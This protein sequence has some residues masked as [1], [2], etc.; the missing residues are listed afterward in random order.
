MLKQQLPQA[1]DRSSSPTRAGVSS[2]RAQD[3]TEDLATR[4]A[5][6]VG[7]RH[8][9]RRSLAPPTERYLVALGSAVQISGPGRSHRHGRDPGD[10]QPQGDVAVLRLPRAPRRV[11]A[12]RGPR[13]AE[14]AR[15]GV[16]VPACSSG[17]G[18]RRPSPTSWRPRS[19]PGAPSTST[20]SSSRPRWP[21]S[22]RS[23]NRVPPDDAMKFGINFLPASL[24]APSLRGRRACRAGSSGRPVAPPDHR[25]VHGA[26]GHRTTSPRLKKQVRALRRLGFGFAVDDAG[27]GYA[28][29]TVIAA[30]EPSIIKIDREI[31]SGVGNKDAEAKKALV[32]AFVSFSRRDRR[33]DRR[34][35]DREPP[36]PA[37]PA[38]SRGRLRPG[39]PARPV[40]HHARSAAPHPR[41]R[42]AAAGHLDRGRL[43]QGGHRPRR[44]EPVD[45]REARS[46][47]RPARPAAVGATIESTQATQ[48]TRP[49][50]AL[51][52]AHS[53]LP[54]SVGCRAPIPRGA[55][56]RRRGHPQPRRQPAPGGHLVPARRRRHRLQ[57]P[58]RTPVAEQ[59]DARPAR[60]D[61][62]GGRL[63]LHRPAR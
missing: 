53:A 33:P 40:V 59:P 7:L 20:P 49:M 8:R 16:P 9:R 23:P 47:S 52:H 48:R 60:L 55:P 18:C 5:Q 15:V 32:E 63:R 41:R 39:L 38:G 6:G 11:P 19:R 58:R 29:F 2:P 27:A 30:L 1:R 24:L 34:R 31:V 62:R 61:H 36:R 51:D 10:R 28:S 17:M 37:G 13:D 25:R 43:G 4:L 50:T 42:R 44:L 14:G 45:V 26:A 56:V 3:L 46:G 22:P 54:H 12:D 35:G 21:G 57:Q